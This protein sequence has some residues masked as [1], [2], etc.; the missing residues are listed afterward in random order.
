MSTLDAL[1]SKVCHDMDAEFVEA[2]AVAIGWE[3]HAL[4]EAL[5]ADGD[6]TDDLR[7]E[8]FGRRR[9]SAV[10]K[11]LGAVARRYGVPHEH[12]RL[13][14]NGQ[15]KLLVK[16]G[17]IILLQEPI[18]SMTDR[19]K[20]ADYKEKLARVHAAVRQL[21]L[22]LGDRPLR[23]TDWSGCVLA[24]ILHGPAGP[25]FTRGHKK[26]GGLFLGV[27]DA[28]YGHWVLRLDLHDVAMFGRRG[29]ADATL[30]A[31]DPE[32]VQRD[33]VIVTAKRKSDKRMA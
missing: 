23:I 29:I 12:R 18:T 11:A 15:T 30:G 5:A 2:V 3:Y 8:E 26:L 9:G 19:P 17:R 31:V 4:Y 25:R 28:S 20:A 16:P 10:V 6:L 13:E 7:N 33:E 24:A 27:A 21:E 1:R 14:C 32:H 22:D